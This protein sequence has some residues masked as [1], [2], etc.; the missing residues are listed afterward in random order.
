MSHRTTSRN[1]VKR[2]IRWLFHS[3]FPESMFD[4]LYEDQDHRLV[5]Q[6]TMIIPHKITKQPEERRLECLDLE[7]KYP[8]ILVKSVLGCSVDDQ[9]IGR[10]KDLL[11]RAV[12]FAQA[13]EMNLVIEWDVSTIS[14]HQHTFS[15]RNLKL[16]STG[17]T[18]YNSLGFFEKE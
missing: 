12:L 6:R 18:W 2:H 9:H 4:L 13:M 1:S 17:K 10:G 7:I 11:H 16:L 15:L 14:V 3:F 5:V 8:D